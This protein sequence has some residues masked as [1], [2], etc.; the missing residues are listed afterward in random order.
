MSFP[1]SAVVGLCVR[2][3][4]S[5]SSCLTIE[6]DRKPSTS[7]V[8]H[9]DG[10]KATETMSM[11]VVVDASVCGIED[12]SRA[13]YSNLCDRFGAALAE[14]YNTGL[15]S[16]GQTG[17]G[18]TSV[19]FGNG[20]GDCGV[21]GRV[22]QDTV[23]LFGTSAPLLETS[24]TVTAVEMANDRVRDVLDPSGTFQD[25]KVR[26]HPELGTS[27][28]GLT[29]NAMTT[30]DD[31]HQ[32][33]KTIRG[34]RQRP[35]EGGSV[36]HVV[37][38]LQARRKDL[39]RGVQQMATLY[40]ADLAGFK[41]TKGSLSQGAKNVQVSLHVLRRV[42]ELAAFASTKKD[43]SRARLPVKDSPLTWVLGDMMY[44][45][46]Y[47]AC[48]CCVSADGRDLDDTTKT[49][50]FASHVRKMRATPLRVEE[51]CDVV[52]HAIQQ[53][54]A[55][56]QMRLQSTPRDRQDDLNRLQKELGFRA[57][58]LQDEENMKIEA[59]DA[60]H[61]QVQRTDQELERVRAQLTS[62]R[63]AAATAGALQAEVARLALV[64][65]LA[66]KRLAEEEAHQK[67]TQ[68]RI[69]EAR[70]IEAEVERLRQAKQRMQETAQSE[71]RNQSKK[72]FK[73]VFT[74]ATKMEK[75]RHLRREL[76]SLN[77][78]LQQ[79]LDDVQ[80]GITTN[81]SLQEATTQS[82]E[83]LHELHRELTAL[84]THF[85]H[86]KVQ[87]Y[88]SLQQLLTTTDTVLASV[89]PPPTTSS[90]EANDHRRDTENERTVDV[91]TRHS[92]EDIAR[93]T[94]AEHDV[95]RVRHAIREQ[96]DRIE[97]LHGL[98]FSRQ[99]HMV[100]LEGTLERLRRA[101]LYLEEAT[102]ECGGDVHRMEKEVA[103][104]ER[105]LRQCDEKHSAEG[106]EVA[107]AKHSIAQ[108]AVAPPTSGVSSRSKYSRSF[109]TQRDAMQNSPYFRRFS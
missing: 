96:D 13:C 105:L 62:K 79:R 69:A 57:Q 12:T 70:A 38:Q 37:V 43:T 16:Y 49:L 23:D 25:R 2:N 76:E 75:D 22:L 73:D 21:A 65:D 31:V 32:L 67:R 15:I 102:T 14:G 51:K 78:R 71:Q 20:Q 91:I 81:T 18:K 90:T 101:A 48:I 26:S 94:T 7:V 29:R 8:L 52:V 36:S 61:V 66:I 74:V 4:A 44:G 30:S 64:R 41:N 86:A 77:G 55:A 60:L 56:I 34:Q 54:M 72:V 87:H 6:S 106:K 93:V 108:E 89:E 24:L 59:R 85:E 10:R 40:I 28:E 50:K 100:I 98:C 95:E 42:I 104:M 27:F 107:D 46:G 103:F 5:S 92:K 58:Q 35:R 53:E 99:R 68:K 63:E 1:T 17:M 47:L 19:L 88:A 33:L 11:D 80:L 39:Q 109:L 97:S 84:L 3:S 45:N 83:S 9:G 82:I